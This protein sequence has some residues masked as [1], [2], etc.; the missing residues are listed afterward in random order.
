MSPP[1]CPRCETN[2]YMARLPADCAFTPF[3][4]PVC[5]GCEG[6]DWIARLAQWPDD[7]RSRWFCRYCSYS[8]AFAPLVVEEAELIFREGGLADSARDGLIT[9]AE[10]EQTMAVNRLV[11][12]ARAGAPR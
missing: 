5:E 7:W 12:R 4:G 3:C 1:I 6:N 9:E 8:D 11:K 2:R 10:Y